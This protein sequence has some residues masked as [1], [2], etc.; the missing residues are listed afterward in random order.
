MLTFTDD[1]TR[2]VWIYLTQARTELYERFNEWQKEV[3]QQS[4][5]QLQAICCD[6]ADEYKALA[7][8]LRRTNGV[9]FKF[10]TL[11]IPGQNRVAERLNRTL[12]TSVRALL[13]G[14]GLPI[15][16]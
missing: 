3:E 14:A 10:T 9:T 6:N 12:I 1:Y 4:G 11:Y 7:R 2:K 15:E 8:H 5:K 16:L 13:L